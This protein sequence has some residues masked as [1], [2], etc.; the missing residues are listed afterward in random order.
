M[1]DAARPAKR[2]P[3]HDGH[4]GNRG[5]GPIYDRC[6]AWL[7]EHGGAASSSIELGCMAA[8]LRGLHATAEIPA[9]TASRGR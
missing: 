1:A 2:A 7:E 4:R 9:G 6:K 5:E 8:G 3:V